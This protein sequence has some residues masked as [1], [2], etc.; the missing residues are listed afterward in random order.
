MGGGTWTTSDFTS[1]CSTRGFS[2]TS[3]GSIDTTYL[4]HNA[5]YRQ[6]TIAP[7]L[8]PKGVKRECRDSAEHPNTI[9]VIL[10]LDVTGS[11]GD[12]AKEVASQLNVIMTELY[13]TVTDVEFL[14]MGI[15]DFDYDNCPL[16][17]SQFESDIRIIE[18]LEKIYFEGGG[19]CNPFESYSAAWKFAATQTDCDCWKRGK[20]GIIITLG[21]EPLNTYIDRTAYEQATG[22]S[23]QGDKIITED[24][25]DS[26]KEKYDVYHINVI[27]GYRNAN[28]DYWKKI[29]G[30]DRVYNSEVNGIAQIIPEIITNHSSYTEP[31]SDGVFA[32]EPISW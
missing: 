8:N 26:V 27:H 16:Q 32:I 4:S 3:S 22:D 31:V 9:P 17:V 24:V 20:R 6:N 19:G 23:T 13:K 21:D 25:Y 12:A 29:L 2:T 1:Y 14:I 30:N 15:G 7:E 11:M 18:Q 28:T 5:I 10:A